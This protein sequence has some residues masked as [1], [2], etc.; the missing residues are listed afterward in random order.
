MNHLL[1]EVEEFVVQLF[2]KELSAQFLYHSLEHTRNVVAAVKEIADASE[3]EEKAKELLLL[4]AWFHDTGYVK[5]IEN[6]EDESIL[7]AEGF[8]KSKGVSK[9][10]IDTISKLILATRMEARPATP[11]EK[12]IRDADCAHFGSKDYELISDLLRAEWELTLHKKYTDLEWVEENIQFCNNFHQFY[13]EYAR[14]EWSKRK[15]KNLGKLV[16]NA[17]ALRQEQQNNK[18][19]KK[20]GNLP[21]RGVE[22][23]FRVTLRNHITLS[24]IADTKANILLSVNAI[25]VSLVLSNLIPKLDNPSNGYLIYPTV[26]F[27]L[28]TVASMILSVIAT[29]PNVTSGEFTREDVAKKKI[30]LLFF[31]NFHKMPLEDFEWGMNEMMQD[32]DYLYNSMIKDLYFLGKVLHRKYSILRWT[33]AIFIIGIVVSVISFSIAFQTL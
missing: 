10:D 26:V 6:H 20:K 24:D 9:E 18:V 23:M 17:Q 3:I 31:G 2:E 29:R 25:I 28:F 21:E 12:I 8:F 5:S 1:I 14:K 27:V 13:T 16:K 32:R 11:L 4:A 15:L 22:T 33:Y 19:P 7:I 30:N